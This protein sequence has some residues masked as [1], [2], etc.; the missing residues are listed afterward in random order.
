MMNYT[1]FYAGYAVYAGRV[2]LFHW[3]FTETINIFPHW[4]R[5]LVRFAN[6]N[7]I[8]KK[9]SYLMFGISLIVIYM[10]TLGLDPLIKNCDYIIFFLY[11]YTEFQTRYL[12]NFFYNIHHKGMKI[13]WCTE[14][15]YTENIKTP[16]FCILLQEQEIASSHLGFI[17]CFY[18]NWKLWNYFF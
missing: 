4:Y 16:L 13:Y 17:M 8:L 10:L 15:V 5:L 18:G 2:P 14:P 6:F 7:K 9:Y 12:A 11:Y 1:N 3:N